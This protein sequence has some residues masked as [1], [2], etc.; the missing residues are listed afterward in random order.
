MELSVPQ[1]AR[2][3]DSKGAAKT[4][5]LDNDRL[6][7]EL[8][9]L[10]LHH[11]RGHDVDF[12]FELNDLM[13]HM[14][15]GGYDLILMDVRLPEPISLPQLQVAAERAGNAKIVLLAEHVHKNFVKEALIVGAHGVVLKSMSMNAF[16]NAIDMV[17][18]GT[19]FAPVQPSAKCDAVY[20]LR[21]G[22]T[23]DEAIVLGAAAE[24]FSDKQIAIETNYKVSRVKHLLREARMKLSAR[25]RTHAVMIARELGALP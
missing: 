17:L 21:T 22:L 24:G 25:N 7:G 12:V 13:A 9:S 16:L 14:S 11:E 15:H 6:T 3:L 1:K 10:T 8:L 20:D 4:L 18:S 5:I 2:T 23:R 19:P